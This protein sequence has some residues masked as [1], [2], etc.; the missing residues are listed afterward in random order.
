ME[1][2]RFTQNSTERRF[3]SGAAL[4]GACAVP[5]VIIVDKLAESSGGDFVNTPGGYLG[6]VA[7]LAISGGLSRVWYR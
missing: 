2:G 4:R 3:L 1:A 7:G 6:V 5:A